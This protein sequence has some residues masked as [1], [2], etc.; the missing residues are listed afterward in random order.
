MSDRRTLVADIESLPDQII[1]EVL[2]FVQFLKQKQLRISEECL[3]S[4]ALLAQDW[5][6]PE[7]DLAWRS[8]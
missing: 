1:S 6:R 8:L 5:T 3:L 4:E 2:D 7:E